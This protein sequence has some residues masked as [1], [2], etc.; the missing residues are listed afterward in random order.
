[1]RCLA[2]SESS[3]E[4]KKPLLTLNLKF[5]TVG[6]WQ[7]R[8]IFTDQSDFLGNTILSSA[9]SFLC[10]PTK[11]ACL[12]SKVSLGVIKMCPEM[13]SKPGY[14]GLHGLDRVFGPTLVTICTHSREFFL[15]PFTI[16]GLRQFKVRWF[17]RESSCR[18]FL[19]L[20][21]AI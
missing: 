21:D 19:N 18:W 7:R 11:G 12:L 16:Y 13:N 17:N 9:G 14:H 3:A 1:L 2:R 10:F 4:A 20:L 15:N 6:V 8:S 5:R